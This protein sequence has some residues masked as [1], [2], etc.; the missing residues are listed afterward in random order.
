MSQFVL[1][2]SFQE[3]AWKKVAKETMA[4]SLSWGDRDW[5][6]ER[7]RQLES[8]GENTKDTTT[9]Q[10]EKALNICMRSIPGVRWLLICPM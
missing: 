8:M 2:G 3:T 5:S 6:L 4:V 7:P 1:G 10:I 9:A